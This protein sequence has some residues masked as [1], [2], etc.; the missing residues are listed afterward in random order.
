MLMK[1]ISKLSCFLL[2]ILF[3]IQGFSQYSISGYLDAPEPNKKVYLS[4]LKFNELNT[5]YKEQILTT[6]VTDSTGYFNFEGQLLSDKHALYRIHSQTNEEFQGTQMIYNEKL[7]NYHNFIFSN[8][9][10]IKFEKNSHH[11]FGTNTNTNLVDKEWNA[12]GLYS[13]K[14]SVE[15]WALNNPEVRNQS[16]SR[17]LFE[18]KNYAKNNET[19]PLTTLVLLSELPY[20]IL[21]PDYYSDSDFYDKLTREIDEYYEGSTYAEQFKALLLDLSK[22]ELQTQVD[23]Y[24]DWFYILIGLSIVLVAVIIFLFVKIR[25]VKKAVSMGSAVIFTSQEEKVA[26]L[27]MEDKSNKEIAN[28]LFISLNT[29]KT[30]IRNLYGKLEVSNRR[31][32]IEKFKN[33]PRD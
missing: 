2:F 29:V 4:I 17:F 28:E 10:T 21:R 19:H 5:I 33:H 31:D 13:E 1:K 27:I 32:F 30:H 3:T 6:T 25:R 11:W 18:L 20:D 15:L 12:F 8:K 26:E 9:D 22:N 24:R 23:Y 14:L 16:A 7:K